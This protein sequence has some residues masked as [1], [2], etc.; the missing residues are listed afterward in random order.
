M[1]TPQRLFIVKPYTVRNT[2]IRPY[3]VRKLTMK[4]HAVHNGGEVHPLRM[5]HATFSRYLH[6]NIKTLKCYSMYAQQ[7]LNN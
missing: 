6:N 5:A 4:Q 2:T 7:H 1:E 3:V